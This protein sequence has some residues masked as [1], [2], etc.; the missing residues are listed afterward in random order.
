MKLMLSER[1]TLASQFTRFLNHFVVISIY[2]KACMN[3]YIKINGNCLL[4]DAGNAQVLIN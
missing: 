1:Y 3:G 4:R 2:V